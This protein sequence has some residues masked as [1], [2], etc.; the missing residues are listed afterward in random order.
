MRTCAADDGLTLDAVEASLARLGD[1]AT[2]VGAN[3]ARLPGAVGYLEV[4]RTGFEAALDLV[5]LGLARR[6]VPDLWRDRRRLPDRGRARRVPAGVR[7]PRGVPFKLTAGLH[8]AVRST[9]PEGFEA[10]GVLNVLVTT[11]AGNLEGAKEAFAY[12]EPGLKRIDAQMTAQIDHRFNQT[13]ALLDTY[14][15]AH[16]LGGYRSWTPVLRARAA[17]RLSQS[18][19]ALQDSLSKLAE[20][21]VTA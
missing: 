15:D 2:A 4:P 11:C 5:G 7:Q 17:N 1:D 10:H 14:R 21:V 6:E 19:Q 18:V 13:D 3:L 12:L 8:R 9:A 16:A 20:K